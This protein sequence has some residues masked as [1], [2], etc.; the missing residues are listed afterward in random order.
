MLPIRLPNEVIDALFV[1]VHAQEGYTLTV[2]LSAQTIAKPDGEAIPFEID[3]FLKERLLNGL[4]QIGLT[5]R[6]E[7]KIQ[8]YEE[9]HAQ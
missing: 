9:A 2:D 6:H 1:E 3:A 5:L 7:E 4:D 8:A